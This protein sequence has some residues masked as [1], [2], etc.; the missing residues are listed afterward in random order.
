METATTNERT[1][2]LLEA[3]ATSAGALPSNYY[4]QHPSS[5][6]GKPR[7]Y[8]SAIDEETRPATPHTSNPPSPPISIGPIVL[9]LLIGTFPGS[10]SSPLRLNHIHS[11]GLARGICWN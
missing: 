3:A 4:G 6:P 5:P 1:P 8:V 11:G 9:V 2:L 7:S 10:S